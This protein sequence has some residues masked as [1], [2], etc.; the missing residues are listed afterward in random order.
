MSNIIP[1]NF[2]NFSIRVITD[3]NGEP[4]FVGNDICTAL[5]YVNSRDAI[6]KHC[7]GVAKR[8]PLST[9]GGMQELRVIAEPDVLR[10]IINSKLPAAEAFERLVFEE[11]LPSIRKTGSYSIGQQFPVPQT[12]SEALKLAY[13]QSIVI[14]QQQKSLEVKDQ[15]IAQKDQYIVASNEAS[16][17]AGEILV[18]EFVK[19]ND[20]I[21]LGEKQFYEWMREQGFILKESREPYQ[22]YVKLGHFTW[23][24]TRE[25]IGGK[26]RYTL[27]ITPRGKIWL[28]GKYLDY[29]DRDQAA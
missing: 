23:K 29:L 21:D 12:F 19:S 14:E 8:Y 9:A 1:F 7:K 5:G 18:R 20:L 3:E 6:S 25:V 2:N 28:A 10:L 15:S 11:I 27:R 22:R 4:L 13:D 26:F 16:I 17:K 24:P